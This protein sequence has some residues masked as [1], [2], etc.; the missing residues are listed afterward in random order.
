M[1]TRYVAPELVV[2]GTIAGDTLQIQGPT[3]GNKIGSCVDGGEGLPLNAVRPG[4]CPEPSNS[5]GL[6]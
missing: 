3:N 1:R 6:N 4:S 5:D 2:L